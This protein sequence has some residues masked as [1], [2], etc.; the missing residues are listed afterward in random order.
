MIEAN[1]K[2]IKANLTQGVAGVQYNVVNLYQANLS[3][4]ATQAALIAGFAFT[5][6]SNIQ[7]TDQNEVLSYFFFSLFTIVLVTAL[8]V[9]TQATIVVMFGPSLALKGA[10]QASVKLASDLMREEHWFVLMVGLASITALFLGSCLLT[11]AI[12]PS[13]VAVVC[14]VIY[15]IG[16]I[17]LYYHGYRAYKLLSPLEDVTVDVHNAHTNTSKP[18]NNKA[19]EVAYQQKLAAEIAVIKEVCIY[20]I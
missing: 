1:K 5:A 13:Y 14:T 15:V 12:Y 17:A 19:D 8:I 20:T 11:W 16:Y 10:D 6:V 2:L 3:A 4:I 18:S 7:L 9:L